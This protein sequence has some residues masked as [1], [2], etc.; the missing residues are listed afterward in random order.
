MK[1]KFLAAAMLS[2]LIA[3][4]AHAEFQTFKANGYTVTKEEQTKLYNALVNQGEPAGQALEKRIKDSLIHDAVLLQAAKQAK[5][6]NKDDF[7]KAVDAYKKDLSVRMYIND[8]AKSIKIADA[9]I[10]KAYNDL[11]ARTDKT[12]VD[13]SIIA[14]KTQQEAADII[15]KL[16]AG[17]DFAKL[18]KQHSVNAPS[19]ENGGHLGWTRPSEMGPLGAAVNQIQKGKFTPVPVQ[20]ADGFVIAKVNNTRDFAFPAL[21]ELKPQIENALK[22]QKLEQKV[23]NMV[24]KAKITQ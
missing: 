11:K 5:V 8:M 2:T 17:Q 10:Q 12:E 22:Q 4:T 20:V 21:N 9:D 18:A 1:M 15:K 7:K 24:T 13:L 19:K 23:S 16:K 14:V 6:E 3:G